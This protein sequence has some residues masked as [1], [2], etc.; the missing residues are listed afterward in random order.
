MRAY[1]KSQH[2]DAR[3]M[4]RDVI[5]VLRARLQNGTWDEM[6]DDEDIVDQIASEY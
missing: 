2:P 1:R 6:E 4:A 3:R 5:K